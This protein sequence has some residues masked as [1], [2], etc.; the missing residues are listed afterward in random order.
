MVRTKD[1]EYP[2][3]LIN[4]NPKSI[5]RIQTDP[6]TSWSGACLA[7]TDTKKNIFRLSCLNVFDWVCMWKH[8][9]LWK[10]F[11][12]LFKVINCFPEQQLSRLWRNS[13]ARPIILPTNGSVYLWA[14]KYTVII[15][16]K[17]VCK[18]MQGFTTL[19]YSPNPFP[20][21]NVWWLVASPSL[22]EVCR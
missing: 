1:H 19:Y 17:T 10:M 16:F 8:G 9:L 15:L 6:N 14:I 4:T 21:T 7:S 13:S 11:L 12:P 18:W 20:H 22:T 2:S 5:K 3:K